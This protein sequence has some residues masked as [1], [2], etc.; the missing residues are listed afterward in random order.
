MNQETRVSLQLHYHCTRT[1]LCICNCSFAF[2]AERGPP[3]L[4]ETKLQGLIFS[5][6]APASERPIFIDKIVGM[7]FGQWQ[8]QCLCN[9]ALFYIHDRRQILYRRRLSPNTCYTGFRQMFLIPF[10]GCVN[11]YCIETGAVTEIYFKCY[12]RRG[13]R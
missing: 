6:R 3:Q 9:L 4:H 5:H 13:A 11:F 10:E 2:A 7:N 12:N 8:L 1:K